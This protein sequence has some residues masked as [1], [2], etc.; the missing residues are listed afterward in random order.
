MS[1]RGTGNAP[2]NR[3]DGL[4]EV[5]RCLQSYA[6]RGVFRGFAE[7]PGWRNRRVF[8]FSWLARRPYDLQYEPESGTFEFLNA[9]PNV[10]ARTPLSRSLKE[11]VE[12]RSDPSLPPHRRIDPDRAQV[13]AFI[14]EGDMR[15][16]VVADP[17]HHGYAATRAV[18]LMHE[19]YVHLQSHHPEYLWANYDA[20][21][22]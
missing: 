18:N 10:P 5:R 13:S 12:R 7:R 16:K 17:G 9:L 1:G 8:R 14:R 4:G 22:D 2:P 15:L 6:D 19:V 3:G 20:P 21:Q 11:F